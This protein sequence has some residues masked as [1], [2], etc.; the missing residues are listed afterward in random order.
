MFPMTML[1]ND[2]DKGFFAQLIKSMSFEEAAEKMQDSNSKVDR[3][4]RMKP[5][6]DFIFSR[7]HNAYAPRNPLRSPYPTIPIS[8]H[9]QSWHNFV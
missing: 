9:I 8:L 4:F 2:N 1:I 6:L 7:M 3:E 5:D